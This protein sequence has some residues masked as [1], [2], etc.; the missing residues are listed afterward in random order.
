MVEFLVTMMCQECL[1]IEHLGPPG[2]REGKTKTV[3]FF[4]DMG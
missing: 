2:Y 4:D 1:Y 3:L